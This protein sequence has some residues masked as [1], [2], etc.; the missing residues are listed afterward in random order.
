MV[1]VGT[2]SKKIVVKQVDVAT[3]ISKGHYSIG[4]VSSAQ[5][6]VKPESKKRPL[7]PFT[8][9]EANQ[10]AFKK[11][12]VENLSGKENKNPN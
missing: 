4:R 2:G 1:D 10:V 6:E 8:R 11:S 5:I 12:K 3:S 7:P 9:D